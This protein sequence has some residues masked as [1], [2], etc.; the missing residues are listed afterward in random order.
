MQE[1]RKNFL[2]PKKIFL[3][4]F[5]AE[6]KSAAETA[7]K[8]SAGYFCREM[9]DNV[10]IFPYNEGRKGQFCEKSDRRRCFF[11]SS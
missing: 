7:G 8:R 3:I 5:Y 4:S 6:Q 2:F 1:E 9:I 11:Q 10:W